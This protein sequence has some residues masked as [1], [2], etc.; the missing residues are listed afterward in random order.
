MKRIASGLASILLFAGVAFAQDEPSQTLFTN[1]HIFDGVNEA[2]IENANVLVEGNLIKTVSTEAIDAPGATVIDGG[3]G[4]LMPGLIDAHVHFALNAGTVNELGTT[5]TWEDIAIME[6]LMAQ[7]Y[8]KEGFTTVRDTAG[9]GSALRRAIDKGWVDGPRFY[10]GGAGI[11]NLGGHGDFAAPNAYLGDL[12]NHNVARLNIIQMP[13]GRAEM[14]KV[15]R[16]NFRQGATHIKLTQSGGVATIL[17][18]WQMDGFT[19]DELNAAVQIA[20]SYGSYVAA[21]S[22]TKD[23]IMKALN[24]GVMSIEHNF[25][26]DEE[27]VK[28]MEETGAFMTTNLTAFSPLLVDIPALA[29][30]FS[31]RKF[32]SFNKAATGYFDVVKKY[33]PKRAH[34]TDCIGPFIPC[35][36][37]VAYEKYLGGDFFG[38]FETLKA[39]TSVG[40]ELM[41]LSGDVINPYPEGKLGVIEEGAYADIL[42]VDGNPLEDLSVI[43]ANSKWFDAEYRPDGVE[44]IKVI[45]KDGKFYK[46]TLKR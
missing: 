38:N 16:Y 18:P 46:N 12:T 13:S 41:A 11:S 21:H 7:M 27:V 36:A 33:K 20:K 25:M 19:D 3:G 23:A 5:A 8:L 35:Q 28:K 26:I 32:A 39:M 1:V 24:A 22:Y 37:Q 40:G 42:V 31:Q 43:G 9:A 30:P 2:R 6:V 29:D 10:Q 4:T 34:N 45:M 17:D 44:T 15:A 14:I